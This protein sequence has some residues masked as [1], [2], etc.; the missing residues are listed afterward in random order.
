MI[1]KNRKAGRL[2]ATRKDRAN[3]ARVRPAY[4]FHLTNTTTAN[5]RRHRPARLRRSNR[6]MAYLACR[7]AAF[8]PTAPARKTMSAI[9]TSY[10]GHYGSLTP[11]SLLVLGKGAPPGLRKARTRAS[12]FC[13]ASRFFLQLAQPI[14]RL[15]LRC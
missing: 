8:A 4:L 12:A 7:L 2:V 6:I 9:L 15:F 14:G 13:L 5:H 3:H 10:L 11:G 1:K